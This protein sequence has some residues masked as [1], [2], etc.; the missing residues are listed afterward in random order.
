PGDG[1]ARP[2]GA[3]TVFAARVEAHEPVEDPLAFLD[4]DTGAVVADLDLDRPG[5]G[6]CRDQYAMGGVA[7]RVVQDVADHPGQ[8]LGIAERHRVRRCGDLDVEAVGHG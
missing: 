6:A 4:Q 1:Q 2:G 8:V 3:A 5:G 7:Q